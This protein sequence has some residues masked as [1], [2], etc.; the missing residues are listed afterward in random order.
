MAVTTVYPLKDATITNMSWWNW[1]MYQD[2]ARQSSQIGSWDWADR[3]WANFYAYQARNLQQYDLPILPVNASI[4]SAK[5]RV[6]M[7]AGTEPGSWNKP[8]ITVD[9]N[10]TLEIRKILQDW[11][12]GQGNGFVDGY[13]YTGA[14]WS[15]RKA[16]GWGWATSGGYIDGTPSATKQQSRNAGW[17]EFDVKDLVNYWYANPLNNFGLMLKYKDDNIAKGGMWMQTHESG[18]SL[19]PMLEITYN[20]PPE[21]PRGLSPNFDSFICQDLAHSMH[22]KWNFIDVAAPPALGKADVVFIVDTTSSMQWRL[23]QVRAEISRYI[24]RM[25]EQ[26]VDWNV[27][28]VAYGNVSNGNAT[29]KYGMFNSK[30]AVLNAFD[31]MPR[32]YTYGYMRSGLEGIM[33][34]LSFTFRAQ[35][36]VQFMICTD[37]PMNNRSGMNGYNPNSST[38]EM[39]EVV[40][41]LNSRGIPTSI[42]TNTHCGSYTQLQALPY[43]TTGQYMEESSNWGDYL[44]VMSIKSED[45][46]AKA[47]EQ[48]YQTK[49]VLRVW[50][51]ETNGT[52][53]LVANPTFNGDIQ[54]VSLKGLGIPWEEGASY[55]WDAVT[56]DQYGVASPPSDK[57]KFTYIIDVNAL[58]GV[59][60]FLE[61]VTIGETINK[62][63]LLEIRIKL[64]DEVRKYRNMDPGEALTLF[65]GEVVPSRTDMIKLKS[66]LDRMLINDG[67]PPFGGDIVGNTLGV[68]DVYA[69]RDALA[70][71]AVSPPDQPTGGIAMWSTG[72]IDRPV[73]IVG[74]HDS[75]VDTTI[76]VKWTPAE[77]TT[78]GWIV[79]L[80]PSNDTDINYYKFYEEEGI[81]YLD[82][83]VWGGRR[84]KLMLTEVYMKS[85][86]ITNGTMFVPSTGRT[87]SLRMWYTSH[88]MNGR[89]S[90]ALANVSI[91]GNAPAQSTT[92]SYYVVEYQQKFWDAQRPDTSG[93]WY[94]VYTGGATSFT[95]TVSAEGSYWYRV[96]AVLSDG[97]STDWTYS[98]DTTYIKY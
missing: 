56:Y 8:Y 65:T 49:A 66:I 78:S 38:Y 9:Q 73:S 90:Q 98:V 95:H 37:A 55:E 62:K 5:L 46:M 76:D 13:Q 51:I 48:D 84:N 41:L 96:K 7:W 23:S 71:V 45:E 27:G 63:A 64:Y 83:T 72:R 77:I 3:P 70:R 21:K 15:N 61:P 87:D 33:Q 50:K 30:T 94:Q 97:Q 14:T 12:E 53:T 17:W 25:V 67:L 82:P 75:N 18:S 80:G 11:D 42:A 36:K 32:Y 16:N 29:L 59:P 79:D 22:F 69:I 89:S 74:N 20:T 58:I 60:M 2:G 52:R 57:A 4:I 34:G 68:S 91:T 54:D 86:Q 35:S 31:S 43:G 28:L 39:S 6:Y 47:V 24:D 1:Y 40:T 93:I 88:D 10:P 19:G 26:K 92:V 81:N 44:K 85:E